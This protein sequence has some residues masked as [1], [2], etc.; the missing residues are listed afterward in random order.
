[1]K[2][3]GSLVYDCAGYAELL[4]HYLDGKQSRSGVEL[5]L[6]CHLQPLLTSLAFRAKSVQKLLQELDGLREAIAG[7]GWSWRNYC[8][9]WMALEK[10]L[11]ELDGLGEAI[12]GLDGLGEAIAGLDG[13]G[14]AIAGIGW[15][16]RSYCRIGWS[17]HINLSVIKQIGQN[18]RLL[19]LNKNLK[20]FH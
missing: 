12:A 9:N 14:E 2:P 20:R 16:S 19:R 7:I 13:L 6:L 10:L 3:T 18:S 1:M 8:R 5:P 11:Q 15:S 4:S 17:L